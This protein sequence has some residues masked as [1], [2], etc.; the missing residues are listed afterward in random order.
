MEGYFSQASENVG[1]SNSWPAFFLAVG[2]VSNLPEPIASVTFY[3]VPQDLSLVHILNLCVVG[4]YDI[5]SFSEADFC[6][7][8]LRLL[9]EENT[10]VTYR[11]R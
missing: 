5:S 10:F 3:S 1:Q 7:T 9:F 4:H 8:Y 2:P 11:C 6:S